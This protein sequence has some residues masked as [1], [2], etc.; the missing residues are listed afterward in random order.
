MKHL[1]PLLAVLTLTACSHAD[2]T[3]TTE[4]PKKEEEPAKEYK[5]DKYVYIDRCGTLHLRRLCHAK[6]SID[7]IHIGYDSPITIIAIDT[8][9]RKDFKMVCPKCVE[10]EEYELVLQQ[11][12]MVS[13]AGK[14]PPSRRK[15]IAYTRN[16]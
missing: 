4:T 7:S 3:V 16:I 10:D 12:R 8:L 11:I 15:K 1:L 14:V 5:L 2:K 9:E 13:N 6:P